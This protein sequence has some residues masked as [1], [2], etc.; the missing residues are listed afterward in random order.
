M[1]TAT[2][3]DF[4]T[5]EEQIIA[6]EIPD[7][8]ENYALVKA[9]QNGDGDATTEL[10]I[11]NGRLVLQMLKKYAWLPDMKDD[12]LQEGLL[13]IQKAA[14]DFSFDYDTAFSTYAVFQIRR[15]IN[16]YI[17]K[18]IGSV[19][20]PG[21]I[22]LR[23]VKIKQ[24]EA[25]RTGAGLPPLQ[26]AEI[27][28]MLGITE[29]DVIATRLY[30]RSVVSLDETMGDDG[31]TTIG[32]TVQSDDGDIVDVVTDREMFG[33]LM[34]TVKAQLSEREF[35]MIKMKF[36]LG[37]CNTETTYE[38]IGRYYNLTRQRAEQIIN[39]ALRRLKAS[40]SVQSLRQ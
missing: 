1:N 17:N 11:R 6:S 28:E 25:E 10:M 12:L 35:N 27:A 31:D 14:M 30:A 26:D 2:S 16:N 24:I 40:K 39:R 23:A 5:L 18:N 36:G 21:Y 33:H 37:E 32:D 34:E 20:I 4:M 38:E 22:R 8:D 7:R 15:Y 29:D 13:G 3:S 19:S 9:V